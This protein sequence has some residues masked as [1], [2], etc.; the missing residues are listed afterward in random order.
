MG[1]E[2]CLWDLTYGAI[3]RQ[4]RVS[5]HA[6]VVSAH[7]ADRTGAGAIIDCR[8]P[9][10]AFIPRLRHT[11]GDDVVVDLDARVGEAPV[12]THEHE[13]VSD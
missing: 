5:R 13:V 1:V 6:E 7:A 2:L 9:V 10:G 3:F 8:R 4:R 11:V 12:P